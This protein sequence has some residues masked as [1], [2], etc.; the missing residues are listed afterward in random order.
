MNR[1]VKLI[2]KLG[3]LVPILLMALGSSAVAF[4]IPEEPGQE[5]ILHRYMKPQNRAFIIVYDLDGDG[6]GDYMT[7][8]N[9]GQ[10]YTIIG[11]HPIYYGVDLNGDGKLDKATEVFIDTAQDGLN[12]NEMSLVEWEEAQKNVGS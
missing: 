12:G 3:L 8:R 9:I 10:N 5:M 7:Q 11:K 1:I 6:K 2:V 4:D